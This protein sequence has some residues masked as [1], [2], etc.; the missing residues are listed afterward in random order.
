MKQSLS[1]FGL[2]TL[3]LALSGC[4]FDGDGDGNGGGGGGGTAGIVATA[5]TLEFAPGGSGSLVANDTIGGAAATVGASGNATVSAEG[6]LPAGF[7]IVDGTL[8]AAADAAPGTGTIT[9][10]LCAAGSSDRC[11]TATAAYTLLRNVG[12][13]LVGPTALAATSSVSVARAAGS[14]RARPASAACPDV[15][16]G[17]DPLAGVVLTPQKTDG[18]ASGAAITTGTCGEFSATVP[19]DATRLAVAATA[20]TAARTFDITVFAGAT[21]LGSVLPTGAGYEI[22][23]LFQ[24]N[25]TTIGLSVVDSATKKA[26]LGL[27]GSAVTVQVGSAAAPV[28]SFAASTTTAASSS[29]LVMDAS[30]SMSTIVYTDPASG[31][32]FDRLSLASLAAGE[33]LNGK[34]PGDESAM[35][36]F[37]DATT[38]MTDTVLAGLSFTSTTTGSATTVTVGADGF[39]ASVGPLLTIANLYNDS[40]AIYSRC[41]GGAGG[42]L[43]ASCYDFL[44]G[45]DTTLRLSS[46]FRWGGSTALWASAQQ[47]VGLVAARSNPRKV[48]VAMTDGQD[49]AS[50]SSTR[51]TLIAAAK[52]AG[53]PV[54]MV[55]FG[56]ASSVNE[57]QMQQ[58]ATDTGGSYYRQEDQNIVGI[59][60]AIQT[61]IRFQYSATLGGVTLASG[62]TVTVTLDGGATRAITLP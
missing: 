56:N 10:K 11:S 54:W 53:V 14:L 4:W 24:V 60:Q 48:V 62:Q 55:A 51:L 23:S 59:F 42:T 3:T 18:S 7:S 1:A 36:I 41:Y 12:G 28:S 9:Y 38:M 35:M 15:P 52:A 31:K 21:S 26:V 13:R 33:F 8:T 29:L 16:V 50:G 27:P 43:S 17:Y 49:N 34:D 45:S 30:G 44:S 61:G 46:S 57:T 6:T 20:T 58:V 39:T 19:P 47:A 32:S 25:P 37:D 5:D 2:C 40:S 22:A